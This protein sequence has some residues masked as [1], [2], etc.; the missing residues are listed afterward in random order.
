LNISSKAPAAHA[1]SR[2]PLTASDQGVIV[3]VRL[4]PR[5]RQSSIEGLVTSQ[6]ARGA[7][8]ALAVRVT[9]APVDGAANA[10]L[11][12]L[13]A[14]SWKLP[15]SAFEI[16]S[17]STSRTKRVL[18]RGDSATLLKHITERIQTQ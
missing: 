15:P 4:T 7:A 1:V 3:T 13:L 10:A 17:G 11:A 6:D 12:Q 16:V 5:A 2:L 9:A 18:V 8:T 14:R